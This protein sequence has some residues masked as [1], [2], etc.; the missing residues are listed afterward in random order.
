M[1]NNPVVLKKKN[2]LPYINRKRLLIAIGLLI[3]SAFL[4]AGR[5]LIVDQE[6]Q[7]ADVIFVLSGADGRVEEALALVDKG[8]SDSIVLT[9]TRGFR[10]SEI[11]RVTRK[12][13]SN[14]IYTDYESTSTLASAEFSKDLMEEQNLSSA[15][16]VS[17]DYH[18]RRTKLNYD[19][20][21][22]GSGIELIYIST[23]SSYLPLRWWTDKYSIGVTGSEYIKLIGNF[24]GIHGALAKRKLYEFDNYFFS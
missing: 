24:V 14:N 15:L 13:V 18:M 20:A 17:S 22:Q 21:F 5:W 3:L 23:E 4:Y 2:T 12:V 6:P 7:T 11:A 16:I 1:N 19:R 8:F 9:N 10:D